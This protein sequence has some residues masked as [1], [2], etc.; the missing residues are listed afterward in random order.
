M[1]WTAWHEGPMEEEPMYSTPRE[2]VCPVRREVFVGSAGAR[3]PSPHHWGEAIDRV[4]EV[5]GVWWAVSGRVLPEYSTAV[6]HCPFC[7]V[8]LEASEI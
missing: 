5:D 6:R 7:G 8:L 1:G 4:I 3:S 2:H